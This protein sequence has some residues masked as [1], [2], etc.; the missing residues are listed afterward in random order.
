[1]KLLIE[2]AVEQDDAVEAHLR[3]RAD[4]KTLRALI[5][6]CLS[7]SFVPFLLALPSKQGV[8]PLLNA[9][10]STCRARS[11]VDYMGLSLAMRQKH[12]TSR[13]VRMTWRFLAQRS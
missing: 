12:V 8:R 10:V 11:T 9:V 6:S 7:L 4:V 3:H 1:V 2:A 5:K 13:A